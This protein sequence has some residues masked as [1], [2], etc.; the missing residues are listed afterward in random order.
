MNA[1]EKSGRVS[2]TRVV[3]YPDGT[4]DTEITLED[5]DTIIYSAAAPIRRGHRIVAEGKVMSFISAL[6]ELHPRYFEPTFRVNITHL[7]MN[8]KNMVEKM[9]KKR[10]LSSKKI[11]DLDDNVTYEEV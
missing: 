7:S 8:F 10:V 4:S 5:G 11:V 9:A 3:H 6:M 1:V 2:E